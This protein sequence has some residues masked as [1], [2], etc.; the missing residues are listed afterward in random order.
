MTE[1][2]E[3]GRPRR[4]VALMATC[5]VDQLAPEVGVAVVRVLRGQGVEVEFPRAQTCCGQAAWNGGLADEARAL[6]ERV[7]ELFEPYEAVV[8][9]SGSCAGMLHHG[10]AEI[11]RDDEAWL[12]RARALAAK[13]H[14]FSQ[15][16]VRVLGVV[17]LGAQRAGACAYHPSCHATRVL[18][19]GD[20]PRRLLAA[21]RGLELVPLPRAEDCCG[22]G[23]SFCAKLPELSDAIVGA[24]VAHLAQSGA[25]TL[26]STDVGCLLN[27]QGACRH[28]GLPI[29]ALHIAQVLERRAGGAA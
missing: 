27:I 13:T 1:R 24:K 14:E 26:V 2:M 22:F 12:P 8:V 5:L 25:D 7:I 3:S 15:Y 20:E 4:R 28:R 29:E 10:Y 11:F 18:G 19:L 16:L 23:G 9:P 17:D 21:V 6:A